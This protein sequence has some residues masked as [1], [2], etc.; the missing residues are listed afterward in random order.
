MKGTPEPFYTAK[1]A[2]ARL[3]LSKSTF[4]KWVRRGFI[5]KVILP[6]MKQGLYPKRDIEALA[7][8]IS[9]QQSILIFSH[10]SPAD[11]VEELKIARKYQRSGFRFSLVERIALQQKC[12]FCFYSLKLRG[13]VIAYGSMLSL[14]DE[15]L[16][17]LL[18]G[19]RKERGIT[20]AMVLPFA[21]LKPFDVYLDILTVDPDLP[22]HLMRYYAGVLIYR[23]IDLL[24]HWLENDYQIVGIYVVAYSEHEEMILRK[25]GFRYMRGKSLIANRKPYHYL[26]DV[27]GTEY[28]QLLQKNYQRHLGT[29]L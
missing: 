3:G 17:D 18:T 24:F 9:T 10:S 6:G 26:M 19:K 13:K 23:F 8:S 25:L 29:L 20:P 15:I 5:P 2:Q 1:E 28:L 11:L 14:S 27:S 4:Y 16:D 7:L 12:R 22:R 21:R